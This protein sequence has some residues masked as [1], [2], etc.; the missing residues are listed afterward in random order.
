MLSKKR[1]KKKKDVEEKR[2]ERKKLYKKKDAK[3]ERCERKKMQKKKKGGKWLL[4]QNQTK[5][6]G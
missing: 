6:L 3:E 1:C 5:C 4:S 2:C